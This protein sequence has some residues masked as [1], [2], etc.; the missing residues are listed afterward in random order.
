ME[1]HVLDG[2]EDYNVP[3]HGV[4][5]PS[6]KIS[7]E[8]KIKFNIPDNCSNLD[9]LKILCR[10][11][12]KNLKLKK[13]S[14]EYNKYA[15]RAKYELDIVTELGFVDYFLLV[16]TV[17]NF[18]NKKN[19]PTGISRGSCGGSLILYLIGV[20][21][22][23][24]LKYDLYF[25]RFISKTRAKK[26]VVDGVTYLDGNLMCD[27]DLDIDFYRRNE[28]LEFLNQTFKGKTA[29]ILTL[30]TLS[31]KLLIKEVGKTVGEKSETEMTQTANLIPKLFGKVE[32]IESAYE[33][34]PEFKEWC[35]KN[36]R[37]YE[38]ALGL[39]DLIKNKGVHPSG[40]MISFNDL[41]DCCP[42]ETS[43]DG[44][45]SAFDMKWSSHINVKLDCLG[46]RTVSLIDDVCKRVGLNPKTID[47]NDP[48]IYQFLYDIKHPYGI[49]QLETHTA[50][51][52]LQK[53]K[54]KNIHELSAVLAIARPGAL[55]FID[56][57]SR[58]TNTGEIE[59]PDVESKELKDILAKTG[60]CL[61]FQETL[62]KIA[63]EV[64]GL[65]AE[66]GELMR[67]ACGKKKK[68]EMQTFEEL[69]K[70]KGRELNIPKSAEF[71]WNIALSSADYSFNA[72]HSYGYSYLSAICVYLKH[73]HPKE[74][75][76]ALLNMAQHE[77][78][79]QEVISRIEQELPHFRIKLLS[80]CIL[81]SDTN[82][83]IEGDNI[84]FGLCL[85]KGIS[86]KAIDK[87]RDFKKIYNN[88]FELF[89]AAEEVGLT[90][91][92]FTPLIQAG[93]FSDYRE[94]RS[95]TVLEA[96]L[97]NILNE[98]EKKYIFDVGS[99][100]DYNLIAII[101]ALTLKKGENGKEIIKQSRY[102]TIKKKYAPYKQIFEIN[103]K[104]ELFANW[105]YERILM[106]YSCAQS[107]QEVFQEKYNYLGTV[108]D[109]I[110]AEEK[111]NIRFVATVKE[112]ANG[113]SKKGTKWFRCTVTDETGEINVMLFNNVIEEVKSVNDD[114]LPKE[115]DIIYVAGNKIGD[116]VFSNVIYIENAK[117]YIKLGK[118]KAD[119]EQEEKE[120]METST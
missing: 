54:P 79:P 25:E 36:S 119:I 77:P 46:L 5:L 48:G 67:R 24:P 102:E 39:R 43:K 50:F 52:A 85:I 74:F 28:V 19:I 49:F 4:R 93:A 47:I 89:R 96:Q 112:T 95:R 82:F 29:K 100:Y 68:E 31:G 117:I 108:Q 15:Q 110:Q 99:Q 69:I 9:I 56:A 86:D 60:G 63:R 18:C 45:V 7:E 94:N 22:L 38:I 33:S 21:G 35:D 59:Y 73:Y 11:G 78:A 58:F 76:L 118:L 65:T 101:K 34:V 17:I 111:R 51:K 32:D 80:P 88:K 84:R 62:I 83:K 37:I 97:W 107:L 92:V 40:I 72:S 105:Y 20:T 70:N 116:A 44:E 57:Y 12:F 104:N 23:D 87:L 42:I 14:E 10:I 109:G 91:S 27:V 2:Y 75:F 13:D 8:D 6:F 103:H 55:S 26:K 81:K 98:R 1:S 113:V 114:K 115:D 3:L 66:Q 71:F 16:W 90:M 41:E 53:I 64:F 30:N 106:G 120:K 61:L